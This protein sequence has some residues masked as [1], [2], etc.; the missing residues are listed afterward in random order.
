MTAVTTTFMS[1]TVS[2]PRVVVPSTVG[3]CTFPNTPRRSATIAP[4]A[5]AAS[6]PAML[7]GAEV[8]AIWIRILPVAPFGNRPL[9]YSPSSGV[10]PRARVAVVSA[11]LASGS[12]SQ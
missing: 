9:P 8:F 4:A 10:R 7:F 2:K 1:M 6:G 5:N 3:S 12:M 11:R